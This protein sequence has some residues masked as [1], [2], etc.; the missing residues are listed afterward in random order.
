MHNRKE[1]SLS[2]VQIEDTKAERDRWETVCLNLQS[3]E[4]L[5]SFPMLKTIKEC[6]T[7]SLGSPPAALTAG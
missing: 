7:S 1:R 6:Q 2:S 3:L 4:I 5:W